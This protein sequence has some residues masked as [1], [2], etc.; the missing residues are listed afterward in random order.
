[1]SSIPVSE[2][3]NAD[4]LKILLQFLKDNY[5]TV[6]RQLNMDSFCSISTDPQYVAGKIDEWA[7]D[8]DCGTT[9]CLAGWTVAIPE[10]YKEALRFREYAQLIDEVYSS[11]SFVF[12]YLF[13]ADWDDCL[14]DGINRIERLIRAVDEEDGRFIEYLS[15]HSALLVELYGINGDNFWESAIDEAPDYVEID[16]QEEALAA[17]PLYET[18]SWYH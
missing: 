12:N 16:T 11:E 8:T 13:D 17:F 3:I 4:N 14:D 2:I 10:F 15:E 1:M 18:P 5:D 6:E 7:G 9:L